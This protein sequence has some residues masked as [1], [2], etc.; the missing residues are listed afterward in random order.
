MGKI[1]S[2]STVTPPVS[3]SDMLIGTDV[4]TNNATKNFTVNQLAE[5]ISEELGPGP[6]GPPGP[7]GTPGT[8]GAPGVPGMVWSGDWDVD[9]DYDETSVVYYLG[10]SYI[11]LGFVN[12]GADTPDIDPLW[13][14]VAQKGADAP[15]G[16]AGWNLTGNAG[17]NPSTN[18]I[19]TTDFVS[20]SLKANNV[21][22]AQMNVNEERFKFFK[23]VELNRGAE[24]ARIIVTSDT[25]GTAEMVTD[26]TYQGHLRLINQVAET[27]II[28]TQ[29]TEERI[30]T[31]PNASGTMPLSVGGKPANI[32]GQITLTDKF[33]LTSTQIQG[34]T[35]ARLQ[36][37]APPGAGKIYSILKVTY[38]YNYNSTPY[39]SVSLALYYGDPIGIQAS[40]PTGSSVISSVSNRIAFTSF[41]TGLNADDLI[42]TS[43][44]IGA[45]GATGTGNGTLDV[46]ITYDILTV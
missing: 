13:E 28:A 38:K 35:S 9:S 19:G 29:S 26:A 18:F 36:L 41:S 7:P 44:L 3:G 11:A 15:P 5:F 20:V 16:T 40:S 10:S 37:L 23:N 14:L 43:I 32:S 2:Y 22:Y 39:N 31:L 27:K 12:A 33:S 1:S 24:F 25:G 30:I 17:T 46:Y 34:L 8:P 21:Q 42:N 6:Q 45:S 4:S